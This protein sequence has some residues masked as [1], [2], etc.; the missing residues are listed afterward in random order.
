MTVSAANPLSVAESEIATYTVVLDS[1]ATADVTITPV[2]G[3]GARVSVSPRTNTF[4]P[5]GWNTP[6][7]FTARGLSDD[8]S[9]DESVTV[10]HGVASNDW[11]YTAVL[12]NSV[13]VSVSDTTPEQQ[14]PPSRIK[15]RTFHIRF[16]VA[17]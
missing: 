3:D 12:A 7:T 8:D 14:G 17:A 9:A 13:T 1:Q 6:L 4:S 2:S 16:V 11:K 10:G 5:S 15:S